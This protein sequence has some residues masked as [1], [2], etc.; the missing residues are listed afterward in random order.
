MRQRRSARSGS[1]RFR[2]GV[3]G[4]NTAGHSFGVDAVEDAA[5]H[6]IVPAWSNSSILVSPTTVAAQ[7]GNSVS[8]PSS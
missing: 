4:G 1:R 6:S 3:S 5:V 8:S 2:T 7:S